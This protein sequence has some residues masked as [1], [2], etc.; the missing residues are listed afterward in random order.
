MLREGRYSEGVYSECMHA[1]STQSQRGALAEVA[2]PPPQQHNETAVHRCMHATAARTTYNVFTNKADTMTHTTG[3]DYETLIARCAYSAF[4]RALS[5][6][7][8]HEW[9]W[10][11]ALMVGRGREAVIE[12]FAALGEDDTWALIDYSTE[13]QQVT[14]PLCSSTYCWLPL[15][16]CH[17]ALF[18]D[19]AVGGPGCASL[20]H[21]LVGADGSLYG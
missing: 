3:T 11:A 4:I 15:A 7:P 5:S 14:Q 8:R 18:K 13:S 6:K 17:P 19:T 16:L 21:H 10:T 12:M 2:A 1:R 9:S 20:G